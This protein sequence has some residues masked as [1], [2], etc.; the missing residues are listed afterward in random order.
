MSR[1]LFLNNTATPPFRYTQ[2]DI[3]CLF[4]IIQLNSNKY[5]NK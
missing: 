5:S 2:I 4:A 1:G 3:F